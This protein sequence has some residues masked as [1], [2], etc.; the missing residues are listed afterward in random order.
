MT[1]FRISQNGAQFYLSVQSVE[2]MTVSANF[3]SDRKWN[4]IKSLCITDPSVLKKGLLFNQR[5]ALSDSDV[6]LACLQCCLLNDLDIS[7][8]I[9]HSNQVE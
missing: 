1:S 7:L 2:H 9:N 8:S 3:E 4:T 5:N 6:L